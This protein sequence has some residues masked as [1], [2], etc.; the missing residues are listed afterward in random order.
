M[1]LLPLCCL[2]GASSRR[3]LLVFVCGFVLWSGG[4]IIALQPLY[5]SE[6]HARLMATLLSLSRLT[7]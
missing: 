4:L 6:T 2:L 5:G 7:G 3:Q 1:L